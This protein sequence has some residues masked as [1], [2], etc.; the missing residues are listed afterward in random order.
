MRSP[1]IWAVGLLG[2]VSAACHGGVTKSPETDARLAGTS[3]FGVLC[4]RDLGLSGVEPAGAAIEVAVRAR[5][6]DAGFESKP[7][8]GTPGSPEAVHAFRSSGVGL[9]NATSVTESRREL[10]A[11]VQTLAREQGVGAI[12]FVREIPSGLPGRV[13]AVFELGAIDGA[14]GEVLFGT[15]ARAVG[16]K[17]AEPALAK[18][19][20]E[21]PRHRSPAAAAEPTP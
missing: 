8:A 17:E 10:A 19:I 14:S 16:P 2:L 9:K 11:L 15:S 3:T 1:L 18:A 5:L 4:F 13:P 20:A 7:L 12:L 6:R 21:M